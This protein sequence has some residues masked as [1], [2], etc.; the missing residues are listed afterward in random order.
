MPPGSALYAGKVWHRRRSPRE[1]RLEY[2]M[3]W[4][5]LDLDEIDGL[6]RRLR[7][8]SRGRFNLFSFRDGDYGA[9][10]SEPLSVQIDRHLAA[11]GI[12]GVTSVRVMTMPRI[13]G[14]AFNPLT[15]FLCYSGD[16]RLAA[17]LYEVNNTFGQRHAYIIPTGPD[18]S[19]PIR[20]RAEKEFYVSPFL[21]MDMTYDFTLDPPAE[22]MRL[23]IQASRQGEAVM[24]AVFSGE[25]VELTDA[26]LLRAFL[27]FPAMTLKV[28][29]GI[30]WEALKIR[31]KGIGFRRRPPAPAH[32]VS[33]GRSLAAH[34]ERRQ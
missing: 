28:I 23:V 17:V 22:T 21:D 13:L 27:S 16:G 25:R 19:G 32:F 5:L 30:H 33:H 34:P 20:Q 3:F 15:L 9:G 31:L 6:D 26:A 7:W 14:Y 2:R 29:V 18:E 4:L 8:F 11:A 1:H 12:G 24:S 10:N